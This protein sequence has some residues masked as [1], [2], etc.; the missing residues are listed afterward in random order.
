MNKTILLLFAA[1]LL[2]G[3]L[4]PGMAEDGA[5]PCFL[6]S[7]SAEETVPLYAEP[8][9]GS[10]LIGAL[11]SGAEAEALGE[12]RDGWTRIRVHDVEGYV[13][14]DCLEYPPSGV[15]NFRPPMRPM[16]DGASLVLSAS[17][18]GG[19][20]SAV[21]TPYDPAWILGRFGDAYLMRVETWISE[22]ETGILLGYAPVSAFEA[23]T[24]KSASTLGYAL[25]NAPLYH[26][27]A[28]DRPEP[29]GETLP[30][31]A[32]FTIVSGRAATIG[33]REHWYLTP[34]DQYLCVVTYTPDG[35]PYL[36]WVRMEDV[37]FDP[38]LMLPEIM[39]L[40]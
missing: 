33:E 21:L 15:P 19:A 14:S 9:S 17:V 22:S 23:G 38:G 31:D 24:I 28:P 40:G 16:K 4:L 7:G 5:K 1:L 37:G 26:W 39:S 20:E 34:D 8:G 3:S 18:N 13:L 2:C 27:P 25:R 36:N 32:A 6:N 29:T 30:K 12:A 10:P 35:T 11:F